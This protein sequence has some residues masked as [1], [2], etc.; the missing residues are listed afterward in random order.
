M[1]CKSAW[2]VLLEYQNWSYSIPKI[3]CNFLAISIGWA[4]FI[5]YLGLETLLVMHE[6]K[7]LA[8]TKHFYDFMW[9]FGLDCYYTYK[10]D[11]CGEKSSG[12][13]EAPPCNHIHV[14]FHAI[15][16]ICDISNFLLSSIKCFYFRDKTQKIHAG[17]CN[18]LHIRK[19]SKLSFLSLALWSV[20]RIRMFNLK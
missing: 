20:R 15:Y 10:T 2:S 9:S 1:L 19:S 18:D 14:S 17:K 12:E 16:F 5:W 8:K 7:C 6:N 3:N 11:I 4:S 13:F